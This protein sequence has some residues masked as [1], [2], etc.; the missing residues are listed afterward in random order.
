MGALDAYLHAYNP[1]FSDIW[2]VDIRRK[3]G[4]L[5]QDMLGEEPY[6]TM[7][8][9]TMAGKVAL[10]GGGP[11]CRTW[12]ILRWFPKP[13]GPPAVRGRAEQTLWGL[14]DLEPRVMEDTDN[15]SVLML[16]QMYLTSLAYKGLGQLT[17]PQVGSSFLEHAMDPMECSKSLSTARCSSIWVTRAY[18][19]WA[20]ALH[21]SLIK[22]DECRLGQVVVTIGMTCVATTGRTPGEK[23]N[24]SDLS[25]YPEQMMQGLAAA[26]L[27]RAG[28]V[29]EA[30]R[31]GGMAPQANP[32][33]PP[34]RPRE[35]SP[36]TPGDNKRQSRRLKAGQQ[37]L[38][39]LTLGSLPVSASD[40]PEAGTSTQ[41]T[42]KVEELGG[43]TLPLDAWAHEG[44][45][46]DRPTILPITHNPNISDKVM[47]LQ[48][49]FK[50]RP[51]R[52]GWPRGPD[53]CPKQQRWGPRSVSSLRRGGTSSRSRSRWGMG[54]IPSRRTCWRTSGRFW[55]RSRPTSGRPTLLP[56]HFAPW[57]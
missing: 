3:G 5:G 46:S 55:R 13:G 24:S 22:F 12:S 20:R 18:V 26:I 14:E 2:A 25:R 31:P 16:R 11:N 37:A 8:S 57:L 33:T 30:L 27:C 19:Q 40:T 23:L 42:G 35:P 45:I 7:C 21:H 28:P 36:S 15:D 44:K 1:A 56:G 29:L 51:L 47:Y 53:R 39:G 54:H 49:A 43:G 32:T 6:S 41:R 34:R 52:D 38:A 10:V 48:M 17:V 9:M 50:Q 4:D